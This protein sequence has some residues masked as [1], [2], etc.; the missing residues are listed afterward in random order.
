M[1]GSTRKL[2]AKRRLCGGDVAAAPT[3]AKRPATAPPAAASGNQQELLS[4]FTDCMSALSTNKICSRNA[5]EIGFID[6]MTD[7]VHL[8]G[9]SDDEESIP[10]IPSGD[11]GSAASRRLNFTRASKVVESA[12]KIYGYRI[13]AIY[14]QTFNV[15]MSMNSANQS[16]GGGSF[17]TAEKPRSRARAKVDYTS[18]S[19]TLA[20]E[21]EVTLSEIPVDN[22]VLDPYFL[23]I[24]SMFDQ[25]GA[26]G[27]LLTNLQVTDD[28]SLDLDG[29]SVVFS[30]P[31]S[32]HAETGAAYLSSDS[33]REVALRG[34]TDLS[35]LEIL[36]EAS[37]FRNQ[38][39]R[40]QDLKR[41]RQGGAADDLDACVEPPPEAES[42]MDLPDAGYAIDMYDDD[43]A[44]DLALTQP[45]AGMEEPSYGFLDPG[46]D[47]YLGAGFA[48]VSMNSD[49][50][51]VASIANSNSSHASIASSVTLPQRLIQALGGTTMSIKQRLAE[52]DLFGGSQFS[53]Y[54]PNIKMTTAGN[55]RT[56]AGPDGAVA[57]RKTDKSVKYRV[58]D[59]K[60][61]LA[62]MRARSAAEEYDSIE[63]INGLLQARTPLRPHGIFTAPD[64]TASIFKFSDAFLT[65]LCTL[66]NRILRLAN[67]NDWRTLQAEN[68]AP[69]VLHIHYTRDHEAPFSFMRIGENFSWKEDEEVGF[70]RD[71][72]AWFAYQDVVEGSASEFGLDEMDSD[73]MHVS[74]SQDHS[75]QISIDDMY[76]DD[77]FD[78]DLPR[79]QP[80]DVGSTLEPAPE[81]THGALVPAPVAAY[82]DIFKI[83][84]TLCSV[85]LPPPDFQEAL[86]KGSSHGSASASAEPR[87]ETSCM[88][89]RAINETLDRLQSSDVA[90]LSSHIMFVCLLHVCN[91]QNLLLRQGA[92]LEDFQICVDAPKEHHLGNFSS[93]LST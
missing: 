41:R 68:Q 65:R 16:E 84:K 75:M 19:R 32:M 69:P 4:L 40:L 21:A 28:L 62:F 42:L 48:T 88:F 85:V 43:Y 46:S 72:D 54:M 1:D 55:E 86:E 13:E 80:V 17:P 82:V 74:A 53:Y 44:C 35:K 91:E 30:A 78:V 37:Y 24:S 92:A 61:I 60:D 67:D 79:S 56:A 81:A 23:K 29:D 31:N 39:Q 11:A 6:H 14:D 64:Y 5:F 10:E 49:G 8:D 18:G 77:T 90:A 20:P 47:G 59:Y 33:L 2:G 51:T 73:A 25:S 89:Q 27:L 58:S 57:G 83:K 22:V 38:L 45:D 71:E 52:I 93:T 9:G 36:P 50:A 7:L 26:Q 12:S 70:S 87:K 66:G 15:L 34:V 63:R 3:S 76:E